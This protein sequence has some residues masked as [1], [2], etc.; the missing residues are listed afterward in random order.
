MVYSLFNIDR[1]TSFSR[2]KKK[3]KKGML[4]KRMN[5]SFLFSCLFTL[6]SLSNIDRTFFESCL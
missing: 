1:Y 2:R 6:R 4:E 3:K 5:N